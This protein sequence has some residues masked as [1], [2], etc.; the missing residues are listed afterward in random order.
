MSIGRI[1]HFDRG[2]ASFCMGQ[3][4]EWSGLFPTVYRGF[5]I[6]L[7]GKSGLFGVNGRLVA[8]SRNRNMLCGHFRTSYDRFLGITYIL[9][10]ERNY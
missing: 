2:I 5:P 1:P 10:C 3:N 8:I 4:P 9:P 6:E 7:V